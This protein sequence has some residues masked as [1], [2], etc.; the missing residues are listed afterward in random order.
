M[1][2]ETLKLCFEIDGRLIKKVAL[3]RSEPT[4]LAIGSAKEGNDVVLQSTAISRSHAQLV[5]DEEGHLFLIDLGSTNGTFLNGERISGS[6]PQLIQ[7]SDQI[8]L[9]DK[10]VCIKV[11][12]RNEQYRSGNST[13]SN[14]SPKAKLNIPDQ[15]VVLIGRQADCDVIIP[16]RSASRHHASL[17]RISQGKYRLRDLNSMNGTFVNGKRLRGPQVVS[18]S[19][20]ILIGRYLIDLNGTA[21]DLSQ[22]IA[23]KTQNLV[24]QYPNGYV[25][26]HETT[27]RIPS[28]SLLAVMGPSGCGKSTLLKAL[29]GENPASSGQVEL[30]GLE[31]LNNYEYLKSQIGYVPQDD[32]VHK[33][34]TVYQCLYYAARLRMEAPAKAQIEEKIKQVLDQLNI[35][36][37][38]DN[39]IGKIS[40]G[41]RKRVCIA[42]ELLTDPLILFLDEPTS[43]LDPQTIA[44]FMEILKGLTAQGTTVIMVTH[45]PED[46]HYMDN[47]LFLAEGGHVVYH[48]PANRYTEYFKVQ[49]PVEVY[50]SIS[51]PKAEQWIN[52]HRQHQSSGHTVEIT[53]RNHS[54][55]R[56]NPIAQFWWL[57]VRYLNIKTN[58]RTNTI[59]MVLQAPIIA[60]LIWMI[61]DH[62]TQPVLFLMAISGIW[63]G[64]NNAAREI[65]GEKHIFARER[66][67]NLQL[68]P[69]ISS[70]L[71]ILGL[72]SVIQAI[73]FTLIILAGYAEDTPALVSPVMVIVWMVTITVVATLLGLLLSAIVSSTE[74]VMTFVPL[75]LIP[76]IMLAGVV[77]PITSP[78]VE[79]I[80]YG[81]ISRW[82]TEGF[83]SLQGDLYINELQ[84][85]G[86]LDT[87]GVMIMDTVPSTMDGVT[88]LHSQFHKQYIDFF[89]ESA[90]WLTID[91]AV[92]MGLAVLFLAGIWVALKRKDAIK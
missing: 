34:L 50:A 29:N 2:T 91:F 22:E 79:W 30:F 86:E 7:R 40:G 75:A 41:Q 54:R 55:L 37:I 71:A 32:G 8:Q 43:P 74:R 17:E 56:A 59:F 60:L 92:L 57:S 6:A 38:R 18:Q 49:T 58:D 48:G 21:R 73:S 23:I 83:T 13:P 84:P 77:T 26:L 10:S 78:M 28:Q 36:H 72:F 14:E 52:Q 39:R 65:V 90:S 80:S 15:D 63:F 85:S 87:A 89:G 53:S 27:L 82:G 88:A 61:F 25:G 68:F 19:D 66:M 20:Q 24:K 5:L 64:T 12:G 4:V 46:L 44:E 67:F 76:Q 51:G 3:L 47:A 31:L 42:V 45:K 1:P 62:L 16:H 33:E 69:Y 9:G 81:T 70:K 35:S 11:L